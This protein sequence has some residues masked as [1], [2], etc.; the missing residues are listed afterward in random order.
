M[1]T[2]KQLKPGPEPIIIIP[3]DD[4]SPVP[5]PGSCDSDEP[6]Q[7]RAKMSI[8]IQ[9]SL[10]PSSDTRALL[11][12]LEPPESQ[13]MIDTLNYGMNLLGNPQD[14]LDKVKSVLADERPKRLRQ[15]PKV[16]YSHTKHGSLEKVLPLL[17]A[18]ANPTEPVESE[19]GKTALH[20]AAAKGHMDIL[21]LLVYK[22]GCFLNVVD[23]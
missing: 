21:L 20:I 11:E 22:A 1:M 13:Q 16:L 17:L 18:G 4:E 9:K 23:D 2:T 14:L 5:S 12:C 19:K 8:D 15:N 10:E 7:K 6:I 3:S